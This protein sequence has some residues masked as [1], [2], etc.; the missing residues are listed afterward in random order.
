M[1]Q[2]YIQMI[3]LQLKSRFPLIRLSEE[4]AQKQYLIIYAIA[5]ARSMSSQKDLMP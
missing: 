3:A 5:W 4:H 2:T 1:F